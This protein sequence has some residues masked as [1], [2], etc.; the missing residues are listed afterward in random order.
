MKK[1]DVAKE[2]HLLEESNM[3][4]GAPKTVVNVCMH[5]FACT[6]VTPKRGNA[7]ARWK[8]W[9]RGARV[10]GTGSRGVE[11]VECGKRGVWKTR[12]LVENNF[13]AKI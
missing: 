5:I 1:H 9:D 13:F 6:N 7:A 4:D 8:M 3:A 11:N 10:R 2:R 12:C